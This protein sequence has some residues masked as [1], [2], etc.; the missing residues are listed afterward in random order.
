V[1]LLFGRVQNAVGQSIVAHWMGCEGKSPS[2][3]GR[4]PHPV[5]S[6]KSL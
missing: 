6:M 5:P 1:E 2:E 4:C 3:S